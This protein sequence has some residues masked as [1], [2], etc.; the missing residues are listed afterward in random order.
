MKR[1]IA[2]KN[3]QTRARSAKA[4]RALPS[5]PND[6]LKRMVR[7]GLVAMNMAEREAFIEALEA[8]LR[9]A[10]L[11]LRGYLVPLG[12]PG[13]SP[14]ELTPNGVGHLVRFLKINIPRAM[15]PVQKTMSRFTVFA[16]KPQ[17]VHSRLAA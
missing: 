8:E 17:P 7:D 9:R 16:E 14:A 11:S 3:R 4:H 12:I 1:E 13:H 2:I 6:E 5:D 15:A 10:G